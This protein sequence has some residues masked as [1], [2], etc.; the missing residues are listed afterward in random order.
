MDFGSASLTE[1]ERLQSMGIT[2][3]GL[4][5]TG[6]ASSLTGTVLYLAPEVLSGEAPSASADVYAIGGS[7]RRLWATSVSRFPL[8]STAQ[9]A[10]HRDARQGR[11]EQALKV[12]AP[13]NEWTTSY[14]MLLA[15]VR[16]RPAT[17]ISALATQVQPNDDPEVSYFF[18]AHLAYCGQAD[19]ALRMLDGAVR[20]NYCSYPAIDIDPL[21]DNVRG[22]R[23]FGEIRTRA[24]ACNRRFLSETKQ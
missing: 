13:K 18:A 20:A 14:T 12:G 8:R 1:P 6:E 2:N 22:R 3:L 23:E 15:C 9:Q 11:Y 16:H 10:G 4:T 24:I 17:E 7:T 19:S 21:F 5:Q